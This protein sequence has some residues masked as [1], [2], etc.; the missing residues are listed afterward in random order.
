MNQPFVINPSIDIVEIK[1]AIYQRITQARSM[2][3]CLLAV[4]T[5]IEENTRN[6]ILMAMDSS[7]E[8]LDKLIEHLFK[9]KLSTSFN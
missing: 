3:T 1:D 2:N 8:E 5:E 7:L 9:I 6:G 4:D